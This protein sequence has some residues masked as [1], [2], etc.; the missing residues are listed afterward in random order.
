[1]VVVVVMVDVDDAVVDEGDGRA[2]DS[3]CDGVRPV[4]LVGVVEYLG[5]VVEVGYGELDAAA[6]RWVVD[7]IVIGSGDGR[8]D[9]PDFGN[10]GCCCDV[11]VRMV[12]P[13]RMGDESATNFLVG[14]AMALAD[15]RNFVSE[16]YDCLLMILIVSSSSSIL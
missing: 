10:R 2:E 15:T 7:I 14:C 11:G 8:S 12:G 16:L 4:R 5:V 1:M 3:G 6:E 13:R 9:P